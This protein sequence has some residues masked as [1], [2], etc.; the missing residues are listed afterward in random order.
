MTHALEQPEAD[1]RSRFSAIARRAWHVITTSALLGLVAALAA[2]A[3]VFAFGG[4]VL[5]VR[6][7]SMTGTASIG[8]GVV[9]RPH[10]AVDVA[11]GDVIVIQ[12]QRDGQSLAP[13]LHR[14]IERHLDDGEVVVRTKGDANLMP[15]PNPYV[16]RGPTLTSVLVVPGIGFALAMLRT[17]AVWFG[18]VLLPIIVFVALALVRL[19]R[20]YPPVTPIAAG[21]RVR[22]A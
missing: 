19:W 7:G 16:L 3:F 6:S 9:V 10:Q 14:V 11:V 4:Q 2:L 20:P 8:S 12:R 22:G 5:I 15:D 21:R 13:V 17:P 18:V 1:G